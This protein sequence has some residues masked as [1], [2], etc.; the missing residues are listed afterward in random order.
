MSVLRGWGTKI[1]LS[2]PTLFRDKLA[3]LGELA[4]LSPVLQLSAA[5]IVALISLAAGGPFAQWIAVAAAAS[6]VTQLAA[7]LAVLFRHPDPL[8]TL[9]AFLY[10]PLYAVWRTTVAA[11]TMLLP[12]TG[13]WKKTERHSL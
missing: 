13:E 10:L 12:S 9:S 7:T 11:G 3:T 2:R 4:A 8:N 1:L 5:I 6:I